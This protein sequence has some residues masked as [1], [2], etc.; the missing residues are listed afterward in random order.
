[1]INYK[2]TKIFKYKPEQFNNVT[3]LDNKSLLWLNMNKS[4]TK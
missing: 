1:M 3:K 2:E 4:H